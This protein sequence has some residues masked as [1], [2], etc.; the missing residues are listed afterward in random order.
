MNGLEIGKYV[1]CQVI[2]M[3]AAWRPEAGD[4]EFT[5]S[6]IHMVTHRMKVHLVSGR[7]SCW[8][9]ISPVEMIVYHIVKARN[10][11]AGPPFN[12]PLPIWT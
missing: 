8:S 3:Y 12:R 11:E 5:I 10:S 2:S 9:H 1:T 4:F 6:A 7:I